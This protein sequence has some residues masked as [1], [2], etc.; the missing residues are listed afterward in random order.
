MNPIF[1]KEIDSREYV[2]ALVSVVMEG[3]VAMLKTIKYLG[4]AFFVSTKGDAVTAAHVVSS[5]LEPSRVRAAVLWIDGRDQ[6]FLLGNCLQWEDADFALVKVHAPATK[7]LRIGTPP[8]SMG[9]DLMILGISE[10][11]TSDDGKKQMRVLKGHI[12]TLTDRRM[13]LNFPVPAGMSGS[14]VMIGDAAVGYATGRVRSEELED[15]HE[16]IEE[17]DHHKERLTIIQSHRVTFYGVAHPFAPIMHVS[18]PALGNR[19]LA[20]FLSDQN[21]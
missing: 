3:N 10:H 2:F 21:A 15:F 16:E 4:T 14:P 7:Y 20:Q 1:P 8:L 5:P 18:L 19:T 9:N 11:V 13:E 12:V 6:L 17:L